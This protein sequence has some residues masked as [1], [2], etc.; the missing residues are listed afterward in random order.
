MSVCVQKNPHFSPLYQ[1]GE[2][3]H[4]H[5]PSF[6]KAFWTN[7]EHLEDLRE[8]S[9][10]SCRYS[11]HPPMYSG[12]STLS[13]SGCLQ[14]FIDSK[15]SRPV[16]ISRN[17]NQTQVV[18]RRENAGRKPKVVQAK[19]SRKESD[20]QEEDGRM[21]PL[22]SPP[23]RAKNSTVTVKSK[24]M[25]AFFRLFDDDVIQ[26]FMWMDKCAKIADRHLLA[27]VF[28]Y[29]KRANYSTKHYTRTNFFVA[30]YLAHDMEEDEED[31]KYEIFPWALGKAW[32][33]R[34][35]NFLQK[36]D[37]LWK[38]IDYR[39]AVSRKC[40]EEVISI[41]PENDIWQR[42]RKNHHGGAI[43]SYNRSDDYDGYPRG[44]GVSPPKCSEC[45]NAR[46]WNKS[47]VITDS[48]SPVTTACLY[49]SSCTDTSS[50]SI[51]DHSEKD[52]DQI[53]PGRFNMEDLKET[54]HTDPNDSFFWA[55]EEE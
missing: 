37:K 27:M 21:S 4:N 38:S 55:H 1:F 14:F 31:Y 20:S 29:F 40:C 22:F 8:P 12:D 17:K 36:R 33:D 6:E 54:L 19:R 10:F 7:R 11:A 35:P 42:I 5:L 44:P 51:E 45:T 28:A 46:Q 32:K 49:L 47:L 2:G 50:D 9:T 39:A 16:F 18:Q 26:D 23:K 53:L 52:E 43:R 3:Y 41:C 48:D 30:L 15:D 24:E 25:A 13:E 34:Y